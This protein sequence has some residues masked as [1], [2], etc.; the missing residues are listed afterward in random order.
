MESLL[1]ACQT[2]AQVEDVLEKAF[3]GLLY[4][5]NIGGVTKD[6]AQEQLQDV[7]AA[8]LTPESSSA[9]QNVLHE[10]TRN[11]QLHQLL[12]DILSPKRRQIWRQIATT[13][14]CF[15]SL[16]HHVDLNWYVDVP[17]ASD[18]PIARREPIASVEI[19]IQA[20]PTRTT[21]FPPLRHI[22][23]QVDR[24][25]VEKVV[26]ELHKIRDQLQRLETSTRLA[27]PEEPDDDEFPARANTTCPSA[28]QCI[29]SSRLS[30]HD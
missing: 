12:V 9:L 1:L 19:A 23:F 15:P 24:D 28:V 3:D 14:T 8:A 7:V 17:V 10:V 25:G 11:S 18:A 5:K 29:C 6:K 21:M 22:T 26:S 2:R 16:P 20:T 27:P 4:S 30:I 13:T